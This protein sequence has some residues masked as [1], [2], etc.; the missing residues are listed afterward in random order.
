MAEVKPVYLDTT[1]GYPIETSPTGDSISLGG[2]TMAGD[3]AM[4]GTNNITGLADGV[5]AQDAVTLS[6]LQAVSAGLDLKEQVR[7]ATDAALP[8][9]TTTLSGIGHKLTASANGALTIDG[10]LVAA[11][12]RVLI[13]DENAGDVDVE[14]GIYDVTVSGTAGTP[15]E[16]TR[17]DDADGDPQGEISNGTF[18]FVVEGTANI[19]TGW[20]VATPSPITVDTTPFKFAQFQGL[21]SYN[22]NAGLT[23]AG[24][25]VDIEL[26]TGADAQGT[27]SG[28]G[29]SGLEFD[30][31]GVAGQ[32]RVKVDPDQGIQRLSAGLGLELDGTTLQTAAAG[33]SVLGLPLNFEVNGAATSSNVTQTNLDLLTGGTTITLHS[34]AGAAEAERIE[35]AYTTDG[36]GITIGDPVYV[37]ANDVVTEVDAGNDT[38]RKYIGIAKTTVGAS[39]SVDIISAGVAVGVIVGAT[40]GDIYYAAVGGGLTATRPTG[41]GKNIMVIGKAKNETDLHIEPQ[42]LGK[43]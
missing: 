42:Y 10:I 25:D 1:T 14:H 37:S 29:N 27:G 38:A 3:I 17:S 6:Q 2:L 19:K 26:D 5:L 4:G 8:T 22:F 30:A 20:A 15:W 33:V 39:S 12:D 16:L 43:L 31:A 7:V 34:H 9:F 41:V 28:G 18:V 24:L 21:S 36:S 40:A 35:N 23:V 11:A 13:K 32:L